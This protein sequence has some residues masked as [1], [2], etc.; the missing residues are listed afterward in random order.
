MFVAEAASMLVTTVGTLWLSVRAVGPIRGARQR[1]DRGTTRELVRFT[2]L[3]GASLVVEFVVAKRSEFV[4]L[5]RFSIDREIAFY[6]VAFAAVTAAGR[7][8][9]ALVQLVL[10]AVSTL[11][12]A[13]QHGRIGT[14][15]ARAMRLV[16]TV[17]LPLAAGAVVLGPLAV[18]AVYGESYARAGAVL[19]V[20]APVPLLLGPLAAISSATLNAYGRLRAP[21]LW[22][23]FAVSVTLALDLLL[24]PNLASIGAALAN[25]GG[26]IAG[27][28]PLLVLARRHI[29][30]TWLR[31]TLL[32]ATAVS[33]AAAGLAWGA[34]AVLDS[35]SGSAV[36]ALAGATAMGTLSFWSLG[37]RVGLL[38]DDDA[39]WLGD[40]LGRRFSGVGGLI[41]RITVRRA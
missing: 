5:E 10:P 25:N 19:A 12:G 40:A 17:S 14:G 39:R 2:A 23:V 35:T 38:D 9:S 13:G 7:L 20:L 11:V 41:R 22:G 30:A 31:W 4:F 18:R 27:T 34:A 32:R 26:Q 36:V 15:Y 28:L 24:I 16:L 21:L 29:R 8:P 1:L 33:V 37:R 6:S 3:L